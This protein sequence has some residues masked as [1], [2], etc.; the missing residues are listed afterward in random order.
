MSELRI[1]ADTRTKGTKRRV[2]GGSEENEATGAFVA[3][4]PVLV[5]GLR[6]GG[7]R[8]WHAKLAWMVP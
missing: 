6:V 7:N 8:V 5:G 4:G 1:S 3:E 2:D